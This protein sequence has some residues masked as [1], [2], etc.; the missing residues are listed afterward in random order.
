L[1]VINLAKNFDSLTF[2]SPALGSLQANTFYALRHDEYTC[3]SYFSYINPLTLKWAD[4]MALGANFDALFF[5]QLDVGFGV[6]K[7]YYLRHDFNGLSTFGM[8]DPIHQTYTDIYTLGQ[9]YNQI[10]FA[11]DNVGFGTNLF[12][13]LRGAPFARSCTGPYFTISYSGN[14]LTLFNS[15]LIISPLNTANINQQWYMNSTGYL[16]S[17]ASPVVIDITNNAITANSPV[18]VWH[19]KGGLNQFWN[20]TTQTQGGNNSLWS[21]QQGQVGYITS[22][23]SG[24]YLKYASG[25]W[26][27]GALAFLLRTTIV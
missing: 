4:I 11:A 19:S 1:N 8:I 9:Y 12:Y 26:V 5:T 18:G 16:F 10:S 15:T 20:F 17:A 23:Q 13:F 21:Y 25:K 27:I 2:A 6:N 7:F 3:I 24:L 22:K 14:A